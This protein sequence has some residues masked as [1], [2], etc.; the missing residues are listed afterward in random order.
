MRTFTKYCE[1]DSA[2]R[3]LVNEL[4]TLKN[5]PN[6]YRSHMHAIGGKLGASLL[7]SLNEISGKTDICVI[8]TVEDADFLAW[9]LISQLEAKGYGERL[10]VNCMW[11]EKIREEGVSLSP[12]VK[13]YKEKFDSADAVF[14]VVKSIISGACVVKTNLTRAI[15]HA[16]PA[17]IFV[18]SP[19]LLEGAENRLAREFPSHINKKFEFVHFATDTEKNGEDV[20]PGIGGSLYELLGLGDSIEKNKYVPTLVKERRKRFFGAGVSQPVIA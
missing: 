16:N 11:N 17:R 3:E 10:H 19:V 6:N 5:D 20:I 7:P 9:G 8:C 15:S 2:T 13:E 4:A 18:A 12:V 14:I 1:N